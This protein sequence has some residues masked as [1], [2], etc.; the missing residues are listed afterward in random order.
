MNFA[1][2]REWILRHM[3]F[4]RKSVPIDD[5]PF[6]KILPPRDL[7]YVGWTEAGEWINITVDVM[8]A[9]AYA[10]HLLYTSNRGGTISIDMD[11][12]D[13]TGPLQIIST[14]DPADPVALASMAS[15]ECGP[16]TF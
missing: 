4:E 9:G 13:A 15:P 3:K 14:N 2:M 1:S 11:G 10:A 6:D 8:H 5:N 7:L 16:A 12:K